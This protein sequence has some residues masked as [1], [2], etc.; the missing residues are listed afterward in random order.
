MT[1]PTTASAPAAA[2]PHTAI[3]PTPGPTTANAGQQSSGRGNSPRSR[4]NLAIFILVLIANG[5]A[6]SIHY[7]LSHGD[8]QPRPLVLRNLLISVI[9][10][11]TTFL[12]YVVGWLP[13]LKLLQSQFGGMTVLLLTFLGG[14]L[15]FLTDRILTPSTLHPKP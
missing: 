9:G 15:P 13:G 11:Q 3:T 12:L 2:L 6:A 8:L 4:T 10:A 14:L 5:I 1:R 7:L